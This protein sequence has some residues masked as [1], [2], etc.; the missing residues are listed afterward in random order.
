MSVDSMSSNKTSP[1]SNLTPRGTELDDNEFFQRKVERSTISRQN[2]YMSTL[3]SGQKIRNTMNNN[4]TKVFAETSRNKSSSSLNSQGNGRSVSN[5]HDRSSLPRSQNQR[6]PHPESTS[7]AYP[8][9]RPQTR[10]SR[11]TAPRFLQ[12]LN[13][14]FFSKFCNDELFYFEYRDSLLKRVQENTYH[15]NTDDL[16]DIL[17]EVVESC[18]S[19]KLNLDAVVQWKLGRFDH[20]TESSVIDHLFLINVNVM[21]YDIKYTRSCVERA[22]ADPLCCDLHLES[23][24]E[25]DKAR[26][27]RRVL[28]I[29]LNEAIRTNILKKD[30]K[31]MIRSRLIKSHFLIED[32]VSV[33]REMGLLIMLGQTARY[34]DLSLFGIL[35]VGS[36]WSPPPEIIPDLDRECSLDPEKVFQKAV[37]TSSNP[38]MESILD[39]RRLGLGVSSSELASLLKLWDQVVPNSNSAKKLTIPMLLHILVHCSEHELQKALSE[40]AIKDDLQIQS[41]RI[42]QIEDAA[43]QAVQ[44]LGLA[45]ELGDN[46][47]RDL[48]QLC[49][50]LVLDV[51][52]I[53]SKFIIREKSRLQSSNSDVDEIGF[54]EDGLFNTWF[55]ICS[56]FVKN[57]RS[58]KGFLVSLLLSYLNIS[59]ERLLA[60][61]A[62]FNPELYLTILLELLTEFRKRRPNYFPICVAP[63][64]SLIDSRDVD[65][66]PVE[67]DRT[68]KESIGSE[69]DRLFAWIDPNIPTSNRVRTLIRPI[70]PKNLNT[71]S[72]KTHISAQMG[73]E[74]PK[75]NNQSL[76][77]AAVMAVELS[78]SINSRFHIN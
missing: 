19:T 70:S 30:Q 35:N 66:K 78:E 59:S 48:R 32:R 67:L 45:W 75:N 52:S 38:F 40:A 72:S 55:E 50:A 8:P 63:D 41:D 39:V 14:C 68:T 64:R 24:S 44:N 31:T 65:G 12:V 71:S 37:S 69:F 76:H 60:Q 61:K 29:I 25:N 43:L 36:S 53:L 33:I 13:D 57:E 77:E 62:D 7:G 1:L 54:V 51:G 2:Q 23:I 6:R 58:K 73:S 10:Q 74:S 21:S 22:C 47:P 56:L 18:K 17:S 46:P 15:N 28:N 4:P 42:S 49:I 20:T 11:M 34:R 26:A 3:Q 16:E 9:N 27:F 5:Y